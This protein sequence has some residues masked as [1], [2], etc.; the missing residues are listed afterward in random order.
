MSNFIKAS[1]ARRYFVI[2]VFVFLFTFFLVVC[3]RGT[4]KNRPSPVIPPTLAPVSIE[5]AS[6]TGALKIYVDAE[7]L[8]E[9]S[10]D[11]IWKQMPGWEYVPV[12]HL[13]LSLRGS[14]QPI[15][16]SAE[17]NSF[18]L[19]FYGSPSESRYSSEN[20]YILK[21]S[22]KAPLQMGVKVLGQASSL[23]QETF[24]AT[25]RF[26]ENKLYQP[27]V[28]DGDHYFWLSLPGVSTQTVEIDLPELTNGSGH[29]RV[30]VWGST[31]SM[32]E[33]DH[34]LVISVN[35]F[36]V[37][38]D[39]WDGAG[40]RE[41]DADIPAGVLREGKNTV[42][43]D[44]PG[45]TGAA[46]E[47]NY[48]DWIEFRYPRQ[49]IAE[50][51][52]L[53]FE[54]NAESASS[55]LHLRNFSGSISVVDVTVPTDPRRIEP[56]D[57]EKNILFTGETGHRY[58]AVG[59]NGILKPTRIT[60]LVIS[61][62]LTEPGMGADYVA[63]GPQDLLQP[64]SPLLDWRASKGLK[65][66]SV[67][68]EAVYDQFGEGFP[69]PGA[70]Q[71]FMIFAAQ[72]WQ[73]SP[74]FLLLVG[75][76][77]YDPRGYISN[78]EANRLPVIFVQ[79][80]F[81]GETASD[82]LLGDIDSDEIP[83]LAVG[84]MPA[85]TPDQIKILVEKILRY[86]Q[87]GSGGDWRDRVLVI[88]DGQDSSFRNDAQDFLDHVIAPYHGVLYAPE[89]GVKNATENVKAYF[90]DG[91]ALI[92]YFGH[93]S[94]NM[95]G[96]DKIFMANDVETL[97]NLEKMPVIINMTC[98]TGLFIH[99]KVTSLME[100]LLWYDKG[101]AVA[102]LAPTSLTLPSDQN[103]LGQELIDAFMQS[104]SFT[105]GEIYLHAQ[106]KVPANKSG[107]HEVLLTFLLFGDPG[108]IFPE[109]VP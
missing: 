68:V 20:T 92:S 66:L 16:S 88:A 63:I 52:F 57:G 25:I 1:A 97:S 14:A 12:D 82:V 32:M 93:G 96:K 73:P 3:G 101:G 80:N 94:I 29:L 19:M 15:W 31:K 26:E 10:S 85:Q 4:G 47:I 71:T 30:A 34:H 7:G 86:E 102:M 72:H 81:G 78:A 5:P 103:Y 28:E 39:K 41:F 9:I 69:E 8:Y 58:I 61:P 83:D 76:A 89:A 13:Q 108:L 55:P 50:H 74:R 11:E 22:D 46:A 51:D 45:D 109:R 91:Y 40:R 99:P 43:L 23:P 54:T 35:G 21:V 70:I 65:V 62:G 107:V 84:R 6:V 17:G 60:P 64:L 36:V 33:F 104:P 79:T 37:V 2:L 42:Q 106:R 24:P 67:P 75:D 77:T 100:T 44:A 98:L 95:W 90:E 38:D 59:S 105:L 56:S 87:S 27:Q 49:A 48:L 53:A 18:S